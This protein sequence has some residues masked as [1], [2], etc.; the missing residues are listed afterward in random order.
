MPQE[1][2]PDIQPTTPDDDRPEYTP[3][4]TEAEQ[5][6]LTGAPAE[7]AQPPDETAVP[8]SE[9]APEPV[10]PPKE[11]RRL[12]RAERDAIDRQQRRFVAC[13]R[14][15]YFIADCRV[16]L[17]EEAFREAILDSRDGWLRW[18]GGPV[19]HQMAMDAYGVDLNAEFDLFDGS[20]PECRRRFVIANSEDGVTRLKVH[21]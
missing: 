4:E 7:E 8:D 2:E 6:P 9:P 3:D 18:E 1:D 11:H 12:S 19:I 5:P 15:G 10:E 13:G 20:C 21:A 16:K 14:C 17:G